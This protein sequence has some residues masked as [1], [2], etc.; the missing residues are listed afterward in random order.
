[1]TEK[2]AHLF[3]KRCTPVPWWPG[4]MTFMMAREARPEPLPGR[5]SALSDWTDRRLWLGGQHART[6]EVG[7]RAVGE[8]AGILRSQLVDDTC[9]W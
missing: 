1:M 2:V 3:S 7:L 5:A 6:T 9:D 4:D 8:A